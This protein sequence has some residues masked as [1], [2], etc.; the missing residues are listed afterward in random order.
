MESEKIDS[1]LES[2]KQ[3]ST[4]N[5]AQKHKRLRLGF[6]SSSTCEIGLNDKTNIIWQNL[7]YLVDRVSESKV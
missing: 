7:I 1:N 6:S 5:K 2:T 3:S 4:Q